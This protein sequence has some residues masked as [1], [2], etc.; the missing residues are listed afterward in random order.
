MAFPNSAASNC[1]YLP[2]TSSSQ[3][4]PLTSTRH[5]HQHCQALRA[6]HSKCWYDPH[7]SFGLLTAFEKSEQRDGSLVQ[8]SNLH[9]S[10]P[11][12]TENHKLFSQLATSR[13]NKAHDR[14]SMEQA[15]VRRLYS[16]Q[17]QEATRNATPA[18]RQN[19]LK[20]SLYRNRREKQQL[21]SCW[22]PVLDGPNKP[23]RSPKRLPQSTRST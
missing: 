22:S 17:P 13:Y 2:T 19:R 4:S 1:P 11:P 16:H 15:Q 18:W 5:Q 9:Q 20:I 10:S 14:A 23:T 7:Q 3:R 12:A 6:F 8:T 21:P